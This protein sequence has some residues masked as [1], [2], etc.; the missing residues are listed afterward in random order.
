MNAHLKVCPEPDAP[1][2]PSIPSIEDDPRVCECRERVEQLQTMQ[3]DLERR[4]SEAEQTK[5][6]AR[7]APEV[8]P[9]ERLA[10]GDTTESKPE[11]EPAAGDLAALRAQWG[12]VREAVHRARCYLLRARHEAARTPAERL[13]LRY[14]PYLKRIHGATAELLRAVEAEA[15]FADSVYDAGYTPGSFPRGYQPIDPEQL[16]WQIASIEA[17]CLEATGVPLFQEPTAP[18]VA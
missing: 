17:G 7:T 14:F 8:D 11:T 12:T 3:S 6:L 10:R 15:A 4:I 1:A 9:A 5:F 2:V 16:R 13:R 18:V